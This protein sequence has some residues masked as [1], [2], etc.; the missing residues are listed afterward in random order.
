VIKFEDFLA[1]LLDHANSEAR[2]DGSPTVEAHHLLLAIAA[3]GESG[4]RQMLASVGWDRAAIR[5]ALDRELES[6]LIAAGVSVPTGDLPR[7]RHL[8]PRSPRLGSSFKLAMER[9]IRSAGK[10]GPRPLHLLIGIVQ[11]PVGTVPRTLALAGV[12]RAALAER[13]R[14]S[15]ADEEQSRRAG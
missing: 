3:S 4:T 5:Q 7:P 13:I 15:L 14:G 10:Q 12:D 6:S 9:G 8:D 2:E 11:A 1:A